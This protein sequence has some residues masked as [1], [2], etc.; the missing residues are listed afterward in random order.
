MRNLIAYSCFS[1]KTHDATVLP[2][3]GSFKIASAVVKPRTNSALCAYLFYPFCFGPN[4]ENF[5]STHYNVANYATTA[6]K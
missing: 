5:P 1:T 2:R 6:K 3:N 4:F